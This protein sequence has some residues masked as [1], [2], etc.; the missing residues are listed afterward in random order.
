MNTKNNLSGYVIR[1]AA[2]VLLFLCALVALA[3]AINLPSHL[4]KFPVPQNN[5]AFG[6]NGHDSAASEPGERGDASARHD[7]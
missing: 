7:D 5:T 4:P 3:S 6:A 2:A 1:S